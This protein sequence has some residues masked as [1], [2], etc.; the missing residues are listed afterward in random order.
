MG[1]I[2]FYSIFACNKVHVQNAFLTQKHRNYL[3][4]QSTLICTC[5]L[6]ILGVG[7]WVIFLYLYAI[8]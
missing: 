4:N 7:I 3:K 6:Q 2:K 5:L 8:H 1:L